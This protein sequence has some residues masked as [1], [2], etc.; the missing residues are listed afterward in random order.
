MTSFDTIM[1]KMEELEKMIEDLQLVKEVLTPFKTYSFN[2]KTS[3]YADPKPLSDSLKGSIIGIENDWNHAS[4]NDAD[5][6]HEYKITI[7]RVDN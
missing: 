2:I 6:K 1:K 5:L 4:I 7:E 3:N